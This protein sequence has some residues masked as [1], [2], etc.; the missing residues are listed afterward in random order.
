MNTKFLATEIIKSIESMKTRS[1]WDR[2]VQ[3]YAIDFLDE[4]EEDQPITEATFLNGARNWKSWAWGGSGL[5]Y[6]YAIAERFCSPSELKRVRGGERRP[7]VR[8]EWLDVEARA[9]YQAWCLIRDTAINLFRE[10]V[11]CVVA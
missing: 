11:P 2:G 3:A 4:I 1:A 10:A 5:V 6:D 8:E 9:A 7:N